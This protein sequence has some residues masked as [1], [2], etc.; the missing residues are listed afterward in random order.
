MIELKYLRPKNEDLVF[1]TII[2]FVLGIMFSLLYIRFEGGDLFTTMLSFSVFIFVLLT[3]RL[4]FMKYFAYKDAFEIDLKHLYFNRFGFRPYDTI[5]HMAHR[6]GGISFIFISL[7]IYLVSLGTLIMPSVWFYKIKKIPHKFVG[8]QHLE[9]VPI[10]FFFAQEVTNYRLTKVMFMGFF[11]YFLFGFLL[12][13]ITYDSNLSFYNWFT[14]ILYWIAFTTL[15]P[16]PFTEGFEFFLRNRAEWVGTLTLLV[17]GMIALLV[18]SS[19]WYIILVTAFSFFMMMLV[20]KWK[21]F[22]H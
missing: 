12:R 22:V 9:E 10:K 7:F 4:V 6:K 11:Y 21:E 2:S 19:G 3:S 17:L 18:F 13:I 8:T 15:I 14:F 1:L 16:I 5:D 20:Y